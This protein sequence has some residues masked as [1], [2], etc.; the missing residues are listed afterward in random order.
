M[1]ELLQQETVPDQSPWSPLLGSHP[2]PAAPAWPAKTHHSRATLE[3][4]HAFQQL[5]LSAP[6]GSSCVRGGL[7]ISQGSRGAKTNAPGCFSFKMCVCARKSEWEEREW[8]RGRE[9]KRWHCHCLIVG[10]NQNVSW[11]FLLVLSMYNESP[12]QCI[13]LLSSKLGWWWTDPWQHLSPVI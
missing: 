1:E 8:V 6:L 7:G 10:V 11:T 4:S 12:V 13:Y 2:Y 9:R 5:T 3:F